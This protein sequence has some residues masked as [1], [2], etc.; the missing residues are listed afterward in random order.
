MVTVNGLTFSVSHKELP[1]L[2]SGSE[3]IFLLRR[4]GGKYRIVGTYYG[5]FRIDGESVSP[6]AKTGGFA[7]ELRGLKAVDAVARLVSSKKAL[8]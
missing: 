7:D 8:P 1:A 5:I 6:M 4:D 2:A 3:C